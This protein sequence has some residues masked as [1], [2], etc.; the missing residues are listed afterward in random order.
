MLKYSNGSD[1]YFARQEWNSRLGFFYSVIFLYSSI[2]LFSSLVIEAQEKATKTRLKELYKS[3]GLYKTMLGLQ[4]K[5]IGGK[6]RSRIFYKSPFASKFSWKKR[7][8][9]QGKKEVACI[10]SKPRVSYLWRCGVCKSSKIKRPW[11]LWGFVLETKGRPRPATHLSGF[12]TLVKSQPCQREVW[13]AKWQLTS[14][15]PLFRL[16]IVCWLFKGNIHH[17]YLLTYI[18]LTIS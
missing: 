2:F 1:L 4:F 12:V 13:D 18:H 15:F 6:T 17:W 11:G 8:S 5:N 16:S 3:E 10:L 7:S 14:H 9:H